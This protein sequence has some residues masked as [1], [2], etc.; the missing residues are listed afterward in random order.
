VVFGLP[1][2][3]EPKAI[4]PIIFATVIP[5]YFLIG[6]RAAAGV[7]AE[8]ESQ[9]LEALL[10]LPVSRSEILG[11]KWL[12]PFLH[13]R[14]YGFLLGPPLAIGIASGALHPLAALLVAAAIAIH[15]SFL[16]SIGVFLSVVCSTTVRS[17]VAI[18]VVLLVFLAGGLRQLYGGQTS[19]ATPEWHSTLAECGVNSLGA[20]QSFAF[21]ASELAAQPMLPIQLIHASVGTGVYCFAAAVFWFAA[22]WRFGSRRAH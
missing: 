4:R 10:S 7:S 22:C 20:L 12:G 1:Q 16:V 11:A 13:F 8:R 6:F 19:R 5:L 3:V 17:R 2:L 15:L 18:G 9:T 21:S 14:M